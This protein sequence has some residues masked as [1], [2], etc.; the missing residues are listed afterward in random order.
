MPFRP[1]KF[2]IKR[3]VAKQCFPYFVSSTMICS[4]LSIK[5]YVNNLKFEY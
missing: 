2:Y 1:L 5:A 4:P 3:Y